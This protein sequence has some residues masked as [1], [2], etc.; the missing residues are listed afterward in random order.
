MISQ[1]QFTALEAWLAGCSRGRP[2]FLVSPSA[3]WPVNDALLP[4]PAYARREDGWL[5]YPADA[6]RLIRLLWRHPR[7]LVVLS[8]DAHCSFG[9]RVVAR[10]PSGQGC[11][12]FISIVS[13]A[14]FAPYPFANEHPADYGL[15]GP[16]RA[17]R[18]VVDGMRVDV[19]WQVEYTVGSPSYTVVEAERIEDGWAVRATAL[20]SDG[21]RQAGATWT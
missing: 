10:D 4:Q 8:G 21:I 2:C 19:E 3:L 5:R 16:A 9:A 13:S 18:I 7:R 12:R 1:A 6:A 20:G 11:A 17:H 14:L 15:P